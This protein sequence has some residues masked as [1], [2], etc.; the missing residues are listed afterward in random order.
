[1]CPLGRLSRKYGILRGWHNARIPWAASNASSVNHLIYVEDRRHSMLLFNRQKELF[2]SIFCKWQ[3]HICILSV[4]RS[5]FCNWLLTCKLLRKFRR[6]ARREQIKQ[7]SNGVDT[8][9]YKTD[10]CCQNLRVPKAGRIAIDSATYFCQAYHA[11]QINK[12]QLQCAACF[13]IGFR[14]VLLHRRQ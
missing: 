7:K 3:C 4:E 11:L 1:M 8:A 12:C 5:W 6:L 13:C 10:D 2:C 14:D 9:S